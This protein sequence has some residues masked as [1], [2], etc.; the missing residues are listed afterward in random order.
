MSI[1]LVQV[2]HS[3]KP[4]RSTKRVELR[5][6]NIHVE[7]GQRVAILGKKGSGLEELLGIMCGA[8]YPARGE[9]RRSSEMSWPI[10]DSSFLSPDVTLAANLRFVARIYETDD[11]AYARRVT[12][13]AEIDG[14]WNDKFGGVPKDVKA[15]FAFGL[16]VCLPF[17]IYLFDSADVG[18]KNY[19]DRAQEIISDLGHA[20]G[21][22][23]VTS[24][25][26]SAVQHCDRGYVLDEG[27]ITY[28]EDIEEAVAHLE[29]LEEPAVIDA[30]ED[31]EEERYDDVD[32]IL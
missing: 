9:V 1:D 13:V 7:T 19:R 5:D 6:V 24:R 16:G 10:G 26:E 17:D 21:L 30:G 31:I 15:R 2:S 25:G 29:R 14:H 3:M 12:E 27:T 28:Y 11:D 32:D 4:R 20:Y 18:D 23:L 8:V 22:I